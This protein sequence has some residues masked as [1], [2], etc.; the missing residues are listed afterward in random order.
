MTR[1]RSRVSPAV[2]ALAALAAA[3][4]TTNER[5]VEVVSNPPGARVFVD[6]VDTGQVTNAR[7]PL[8][9]GDDRNQR[10]FLQLMLD[11]HRPVFEAFYAYN[12]PP[13]KEYELRK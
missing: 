1:V 3:C 5:I 10:V 7:V 4:G 12:V 8:V 13:K 9:F 11:G 2:L 6:G